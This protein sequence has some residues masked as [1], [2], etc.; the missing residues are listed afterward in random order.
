VI[1]ASAGGFKAISELLSK[2]EADLPV[3]IF[4]VIYLSRN[5]LA[6]NVQRHIQKYTSSCASWMAVFM[7]C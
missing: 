5:S 6:R 1:G 2:L 3:A 7:R 4:M